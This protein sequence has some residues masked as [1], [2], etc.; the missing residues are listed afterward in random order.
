MKIED[1]TPPRNGLYVVYTDELGAREQYAQRRFLR[2][3]D[4]EWLY[5]LSDKPF[6][7]QVYGWVGPIPKMRLE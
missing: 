3:A 5:C 6:A 1:G 7:G 4:R 2:W